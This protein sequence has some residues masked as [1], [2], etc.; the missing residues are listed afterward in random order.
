[1]AEEGIDPRLTE[2][3]PSQ[4]IS[5]NLD[6]ATIYLPLARNVGT[7]FSGLGF[8]DGRSLTSHVGARFKALDLGVLMAASDFS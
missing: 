4:I 7:D 1:M 8:G 2:N 3:S 6:V 5:F